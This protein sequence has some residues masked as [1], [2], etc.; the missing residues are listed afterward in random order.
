ME[1]EN[2][3]KNELKNDK[4]ELRIDNNPDKKLNVSEMKKNIKKNPW[5]IS[6]IVLAVITLILLVMVF[7]GGITGGAIGV[8]SSISAEQAGERLIE[9][10]NVQGANA[11]LVEVN[12]NGIF[13]EVVVSINGQ[14]LPLY[15]TKDGEFF[16]SSL[17]P[18]DVT[19]AQAAAQQA[20][21]TQQPTEVPK[22]DKPVVELFV[23]T[24]CPYG[25]QAEKGFLPVVKLLGDKI[26]SSIKFVH[27]F[28]HDPEKTE[29]PVQICIREEQGDKFNEYLSCFLED[30]DSE[31]CLTE[32]GIDQ[33]KLN[34]CIENNY[35]GLY[36]ADSALSE[37]YGVRGSPTLIINGV[38][39]N[40]GRSPS[41]YLAGICAAFNTPPEECNE[42]L[43]TANPSAGFGYTAQAGGSTNAQC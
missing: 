36:A 30:G 42:E 2:L 1:D 37:G 32:T 7:R 29:T 6:T 25:T 27:Y 14:N 9:F 16:T 18:L 35:D 20:Q 40:A 33:T 8:G 24:H 11:E 4:S 21:E 26:D 15:V 23:M 19:A 39:S 12:D 10:A 3:G 34:A 28:L 13:Y 43:S 5:M 38:Q 17:I 41:S 31:K 22:S